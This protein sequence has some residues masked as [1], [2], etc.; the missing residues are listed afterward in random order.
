MRGTKQSQTVQIGF[1]K[2]LCEAGIASCLAMTGGYVL[3]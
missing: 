3:H 2:L 1:V